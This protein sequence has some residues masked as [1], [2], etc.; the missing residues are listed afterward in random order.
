MSADRWNRN[1]GRRTGVYVTGPRPPSARN[2]GRG[3]PKRT[4][5]QSRARNAASARMRYDLARM[6]SP[7]VASSVRRMA[8]SG[9]GVSG[10]PAR[11]ESAMNN[12]YDQITSD[13]QDATNKQIA[14]ERAVREGQD[15]EQIAIDQATGISGAIGRSPVGSVLRGIG[16]TPFIGT[17]LDYLNRPAAA[18]FGGLENLASQ[19]THQG[20]NAED[21][22]YTA[23]NF[24][25]G[26]WG[27]LSGR[28]Q[29][30]FGQV[31]E[32]YKNN[33]E[34]DTAQPLRNLE[35]AHPNI[36]QAL[37]IGVGAAGELEADPLNWL[38]L[39]LPHVTSEGRQ[40]ANANILE[41]T[42]QTAGRQS[43]EDLLAGSSVINDAP[44][45]ARPV[46]G[47]GGPDAF[48]AR[49]GSALTDSFNN[50][51]LNVLE[52]GAPHTR[53]L[54]N[55]AFPAQAT[56]TWTQTVI[57]S[58]TEHTALTADDII[59]NPNN[60]QPWDI[61]AK[62][63]TNPGFAKYWDGLTRAME[64]D[65]RWSRIVSGATGPDEVLAIL[66]G[67]K[68]PES[69]LNDVWTKFREGYFVEV[70]PYAKT[71]YETLENPIERS[72]GI[73][74]GKKT[75]QVPLL[76]R[77][78]GWVGS[79]LGKTAAME[80]LNKLLYERAFPS[81]FAN[82]ISR[83]QAYGLRGLDN[84][85][86]DIKDMARNFTET[87]SRELFDALEK[88]LPTLGDVRKDKGLQWL[89]DLRDHLFRTEKS[90]G[91]RLADDT[92][93]DEYV[94]LTLKGGTG[95]KRTAF[96]E[97]RSE[98]YRL[99][100]TA[101]EYTIENAR[102]AGLKPVD[103]AFEAFL[104]RYMTSARD[105]TNAH[106]WQDL[107]GN[108][109][110]GG[111][112][113]KGL[114]AHE[115]TD[116]G[117]VE[118]P[119]SK[120]NEAYRQMVE[121]SG[122]KF[123]IP[124]EI[125]NFGRQF[126]DLMKFDSAAFGNIRRDLS[127]IMNV[128][129][130]GMTLPH[131][132]FQIRNF[133]GDTMMGLLDGVLPTQY[134]EVFRKYLLNRG[135]KVTKFKIAPGWTVSWDELMAMYK[136]EVNTGFINVDEPLRSTMTAG[137][138]PRAFG[139]RTYDVLRDVS[140][141][142][143]LLPRVTHYLH[144]LREEAQALERRGVKNIDLI[145]RQARDAALWRVNHYKF[146]YNA[147]MPWERNLKSLA[148]PFYTYARKSIPTLL[149]QM[150][151]NPHYFSTL[152]RF[153]QYNDGSA[154]DKFNF[155]NISNWMRDLGF[156]NLTDEEQP[157]M[158]TGDIFPTSQ[159]DMLSSH[160]VGEASQDF[161]QNLS[162]LFRAPIELGM[163]RESFS[164]QPIND[165]AFQYMMEQLPV[166]QDVQSFPER[167]SDPLQWV[168]QRFMGAGIP[169][170]RLTT[171]MQ[172]QQMEQNYD[173]LIEGPTRDYNYSQDRFSIHMNEQGVF[174]VYDKGSGTTLP[175]SFN[176]PNEAINWA[177][178]NLPNVQTPQ[179]NPFRPPTYQ[180]MLARLQSMQGQ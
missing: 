166:W 21:L 161:I 122:G 141:K 152:S 64:A 150:L 73:R 160:S 40:I 68:V 119:T 59:A 77:A 105:V 84:F 171:G 104:H 7:S 174:T 113:I 42:W 138:I 126:D 24:W 103:D 17:A 33:P 96:L 45:Y 91:A 37:A 106:F 170:R 54:N 38:G 87:E 66:K 57:D 115:I 120:L 111:R 65:P 108:Y 128:Y 129:K 81:L 70:Q 157:L 71:M 14:V 55:A 172:E 116:R 179:Q 15:P 156:A 5:Q 52:G 41:D 47:V 124:R 16:N 145:E 100:G 2:R 12:V 62:I 6:G 146:D 117:L 127:K 11:I 79:R 101:G 123:Y 102:K 9:S 13:Y 139:R 36:E 110:V 20:Y 149:E 114:S 44:Y 23:R 27:G 164:N 140:N 32:S 109:A 49:I 165:N 175:M 99:H 48:D 88:N 142:R 53:T 155:L 107:V 135:G 50:S 148:F 85:V 94:P 56:E 112:P 10:S 67:G 63:K 159:L 136:Q 131:T 98:N 25:E 163:G 76:G 72:I 43:T 130:I 133:V 75:V 168:N 69:F 3:A 162:P 167:F 74:V 90:E 176:T 46:G 60:Y 30:G 82:K 118:I 151:I 92:F 19:E 158:L 154:A 144:A 95:G 169:V 1:V 147:L 86:D 26:L 29:E 89:R 132:G 4:V 8:G 97:G 31:Y 178:Q 34:F 39:A 180:D 137:S 177:R 80:G 93:I 22:G 125:H 58:L 143:E 51:T 173:D 18:L 28:E 153:Y 83:S 134:S 35:Q 78:F 61:V 121:T